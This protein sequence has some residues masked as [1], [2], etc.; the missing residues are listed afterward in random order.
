MNNNQKNSSQPDIASFELYG[1]IGIDITLEDFSA[2]MKE[3]ADNDIEILVHSPGGLLFDAIGIHNLIRLHKK[4]VAVEIISLA[5]SAASYIC[6]AANEVRVSQNSVFMI[7]N[8]H[9]FAYGDH[10]KLRDSA[11]FIEKLSNMLINAYSSKSNL[12]FAD[13]KKFMDEETFFIGEDIIKN[14]FADLYEPSAVTIKEEDNINNAQSMISNCKEVI[15]E[16]YDYFDQLSK[17]AAL[18]DSFDDNKNKHAKPFADSLQGLLMQQ[19]KDFSNAV[20]DFHSYLN[21]A[22]SKAVNDEKSKIDFTNQFNANKDS[23]INEV[24]SYLSTQIDNKVILPSQKISLLNFFNKVILFLTGKD[25]NHKISF[26][27]F[28]DFLSVYPSVNLLD[29]IA[30]D[31]NNNNDDDNSSSIF[32]GEV[33]KNSIVDPD[34]RK[35]HQKIVKL[36]KSE[37]LTYLSATQKLLNLSKELI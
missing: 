32:E 25:E 1:V 19:L 6:T 7:H 15:N 14:N 21:D 2:F 31:I 27:H 4:N 37:N 10:N 11:D 3:N 26:N 8:V 12:P 20:K 13:I 22:K 34:S 23:F 18:L 30:Q 33:L 35:L 28:D 5:A 9:S 17:A 36:M 16:K 24:D 29:D